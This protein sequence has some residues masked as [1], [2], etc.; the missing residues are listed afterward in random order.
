MVH[1]LDDPLVVLLRELIDAAHLADPLELVEEELA[2]HLEGLL[3]FGLPLDHLLEV[4]GLGQVVLYPLEVVPRLVELLGLLVELLLEVDLELLEFLE[5]GLL[6][7][8]LGVEAG[9][10]LLELLVL[11]GEVHGAALELVDFLLVG[12]DLLLLRDVRIL[13]LV[14]LVGEGLVG[15]REFLDVEGAELELVATCVWI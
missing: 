9:A 1:L 14:A 2:L 10:L 4:V 11:S 8:E 7:Q 3:R 6:G 13:E 12:L 15:L 5:L